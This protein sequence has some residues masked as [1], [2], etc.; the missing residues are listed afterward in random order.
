[1]KVL[2]EPQ[3]GRTLIV[4]DEAEGISPEVFKKAAE[5]SQRVRIV[6]C[7]IPLDSIWTR[8]KPE[9]GENA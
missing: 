5:W 9:D 1:M 2:S 6:S 7:N 3:A 4:F 8:T